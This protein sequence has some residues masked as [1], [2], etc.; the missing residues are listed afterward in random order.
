[1]KRK[2]LG[3]LLTVAVL[4]AGAFAAYAVLAN[5]PTGRGAPEV[6]QGTDIPIPEPTPTVA[7][8]SDNS[9][10]AAEAALIAASPSLLDAVRRME[11]GDV[12]EMLG[13]L[14]WREFPCTPSDVRGGVAPKCADIGVAEGTPVRM[15]HYQLHVNSYRT[16]S[17]MRKELLQLAVGRNPTLGVVARRADGSYLISFTVDDLSHEGLRGIDFTADPKVSPPFIGYT[18]RFAGSTPLDTLRDE[19]RTTG[20][21]S[22]VLYI[23]PAVQAWEKEKDGAQRQP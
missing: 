18:E 11:S 8:P 3:S 5:A 15:F 4:V 10:A 20:L 14:Q 2:Y 1:M 9:R 13:A 19:E 16:E 12:E 7:S 6:P 23:S 22:E 17:E 21:K